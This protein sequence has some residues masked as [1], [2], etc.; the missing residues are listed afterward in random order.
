MDPTPPRVRTARS[1][2]AWAAHR[3]HRAGGDARTQNRRTHRR[4]GMHPTARMGCPTDGG[5]AGRRA[6][7][8]PNGS[9]A[10]TYR[11]SSDLA[12]GK[13][14]PASRRPESASRAA[15]IFGARITFLTKKL[16]A[17]LQQKMAWTFHGSGPSSWTAC[18]MQ[19][20]FGTEGVRCN[21]NDRRSPGEKPDIGRRRGMDG[22]AHG[23]IRGENHPGFSAWGWLS[24]P[25]PRIWHGPRSYQT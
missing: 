2:R 22:D 9:G 3:P 16:R 17:A 23:S 7:R 19:R 10:A 8:V 21:G 14:S 12:A 5:A 15:A 4:S 6:L 18:R 1:A 24:A 13:N 20:A 25:F 11:R